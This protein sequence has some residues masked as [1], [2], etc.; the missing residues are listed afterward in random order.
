M[1]LATGVATAGSIWVLMSKGTAGKT[2]IGIL[3][4]LFVLGILGF[5]SKGRK[6]AAQ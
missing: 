6:H 5:I 2:G 3:I 1:A 4:A